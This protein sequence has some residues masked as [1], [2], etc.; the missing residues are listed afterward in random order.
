[1]FRLAQC[2]YCQK[3]EPFPYMCTYCKQKFCA[4]HRLAENH[5]CFKARHAKYIRKTWIRKQGQNITSGKY[6]IVCDVCGF[7]TREGRLIEIAGGERE[8]HIL[9]KGCDSQKV[10]LEEVG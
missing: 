1:M 3:T 6:I 7:R 9:A 5:D 10:F 8:K 4:D 2:T